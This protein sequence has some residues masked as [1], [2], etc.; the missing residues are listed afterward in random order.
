MGNRTDM[1]WFLARMVVVMTVSISR[2][3]G[4]VTGSLKALLD[5]GTFD[6]VTGQQTSAGNSRNGETTAGV[7]LRTVGHKLESEFVSDKIGSCRLLVSSVT[8]TDEMCQGDCDPSRGGFAQSQECQKCEECQKWIKKPDEQTTE[9]KK[10]WK[11][12]SEKNIGNY[13]NSQAADR[14]HE[15]SRKQTTKAVQKNEKKLLEELQYKAKYLAE[16]GLSLPKEDQDRMNKLRQHYK[17]TVTEKLSNFLKGVEN[18]DPELT[19]TL[20]EEGETKRLRDQ[21]K[22]RNS[23]N[24]K[25]TL[26]GG[27]A[28][29]NKGTYQDR[30]GND[31]EV[32]GN[33]ADDALLL[34]AEQQEELKDD[35]DARK[36][37]AKDLAEATDDPSFSCE[38]ERCKRGEKW[39]K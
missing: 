2:I 11:T 38:K 26:T 21:E 37:A 32:T 1:G 20:D 15:L 30:F 10:A 6:P 12:A 22:R 25:S 34:S 3:D 24:F 19:T 29:E 5:F 18:K 8:N 39:A 17:P 28:G 16:Y 14:L 13:L 27:R 35:L 7:N 9:W 33:P 31:F 36:R 4:K 23:Y